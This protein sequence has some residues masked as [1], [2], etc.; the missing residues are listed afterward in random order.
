MALTKTAIDKAT[1]HG[2]VTRQ[3][4]CV[5]WDDAL[6]G[7]GVRIYP[8]GSKAF[9]V[10]YRVGGRKRLMTI[11][12]CNV[13]TVDQ[14][15]KRTRAHL[16]AVDDGG[17]PLANKRAIA[18]AG[19]VKELAEE[20]LNRHAKPH[21][22]SWPDDARRLKQHVLPKWGGLK[23]HAVKKADV[24]SLHGAL[25]K[26]HP[27][28]ANRTLALLAK[29]FAL[30]AE[31]GFVPDGHV[32]PARQLRH[33]REAKRDRWVEPHEL[34]KLAQEIDREQN[35]Y[36][37]SAFWLYLLT[38]VRKSELLTARWADV[39]LSDKQLRLPE[40][41][42]GTVHYIPLS[43]PA[44]ALLRDLPRLKGN[45]YVLPGAKTG[46][47]LVNISKP[48]GRIRKAAGVEDVR[49][50]DLRRT[51]GSW[52]AQ[53]GNSLHLIGRVLN[54]SNQSTTAVYARFGQDNVREAL[55]T[56]AQRLLGVAGKGTP[57]TVEPI[58]PK[59]KRTIVK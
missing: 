42:A 50:H 48:W 54:H 3:A 46:G 53:N 26:E 18:Q 38:G 23:V 58:K 24:S 5:L 29:M 37:R 44:V 22:R 7:F 31:W 32:N 15:R 6:T 8:G 35:I 47:H 9:V 57:A 17:D 59:S 56:H 21:K 55:E 10:S 4:R 27:Y 25:G 2:D 12:A 51:V 49:L 52:L 33:F 14:A 11:G 20:Y 19:T 28:E 45:P 39:N 36:V 40:T 30:G 16:V 43:E 41:K 34:P 13:L 1:Y